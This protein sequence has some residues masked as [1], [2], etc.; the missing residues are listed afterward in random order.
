MATRTIANGGGNYGDIGT[1]VEGAVPTSADDVVATATS[2]QLTVNVAS[3]AKTFD[4]TNYTNTLTVN[5]TWTVS[6]NGTFV[7]GMTIAPFGGSGVLI[8]NTT[9]TLTSGGKTIP[10]QV[11]FKGTSQTYTL[12]DNWTISGTVNMNGTTAV[13]LNGNTLNASGSLTISVATSG[14]TNIVM[15]GTGTITSAAGLTITLSTTGATAG[16]MI[17]VQSLPSSA[18]AQTITWVNTESSDIT[19]SA[20]LNASTTLPRT[21]GFKWN[22]LTSKW[23]CIGS[24]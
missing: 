11:Q 24:C 14:T 2:G 21:D 18:V 20:N 3:V 17:L 15:N 12:A 10:G 6:G 23:R 7:S 1:W 19:P 9:A 5:N 8:F 22:P 16:D 4:F 13:T